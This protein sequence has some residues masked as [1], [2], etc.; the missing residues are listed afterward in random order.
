MR[1]RCPIAVDWCT[2]EDPRLPT[3]AQNRMVCGI[4]VQL[5][6][7][8]WFITCTFFLARYSEINQIEFNAC[9]IVNDW[10][11]QF[12][13]RIAPYL[14]SVDDLSEQECIRLGKKDPEAYPFCMF[15]QCAYSHDVP[16]LQ[17]YHCNSS[18]LYIS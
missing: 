11:S 7:A 18:G 8:V 1:M 6:L 2:P 15:V 10:I 16:T 17:Y 3:R 13:A 9:V 12:E 5:Q 14:E 4:C